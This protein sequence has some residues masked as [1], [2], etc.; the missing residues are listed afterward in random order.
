MIYSEAAYFEGNAC[1]HC[2][3]RD[4]HLRLERKEQEARRLA[5]R[6]NQQH[7]EQAT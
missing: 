6:R 2:A 7:Q 1:Q 3:S 5:R 4:E